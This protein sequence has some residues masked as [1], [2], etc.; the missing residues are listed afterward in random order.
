MV[1]IG[2]VQTV[3]RGARQVAHPQ[4]RDRAA[5]TGPGRPSTG[6]R[7]DVRVP[8]DVLAELDGM[9]ERWELTRAEVVRIALERYVNERERD[10]VGAE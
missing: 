6:T 9:A 8:A 2:G 5:M 7:I 4:R 1:A 3:R 10:V